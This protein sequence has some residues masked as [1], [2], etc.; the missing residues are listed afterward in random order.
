MQWCYHAVEDVRIFVTRTTLLLGLAIA[1]PTSIV[2]PESPFVL[3]FP[4]AW[5]LWALSIYSGL[6]AITTI[7]EIRN[8]AEMDPRASTPGRAKALPPYNPVLS[9][10]MRWQLYS[11]IAGLAVV[12]V[13]TVVPALRTWLG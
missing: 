11:F 6:R 9:C 12:A 1:F 10:R 7:T 5:A 13:S 4:I 3:P 2:D 8:A